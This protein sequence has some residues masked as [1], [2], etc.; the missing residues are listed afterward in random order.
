MQETS[1]WKE[2]TLISYYSVEWLLTIFERISNVTNYL[3]IPLFTFLPTMELLTDPSLVNSGLV[4]P[5]NHNYIPPVPL[6]QTHF[7][8]AHRLYGI[9]QSI[10]HASW[11]LQTMSAVTVVV[12]IFLQNSIS[13]HDIERGFMNGLNAL[14]TYTVPE[15]VGQPIALESLILY[16]ERII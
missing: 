3:L 10:K 12:Y 2:L 4:L 15:I 11:M 1:I 6:K 7:T 16:M 5:N 14:M 8:L 13:G 9:L